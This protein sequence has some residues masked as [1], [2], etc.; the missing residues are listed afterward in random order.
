MINVSVDIET[1]GLTAG[2]H[3]VVQFAITVLDKNFELTNDRFF[4]NIKPVRPEVANP[5]ALEVNGLDL[6][7]LKTKAPNLTEIMSSLRSW[8]LEL[9]EN[10]KFL[11]LFQVAIF[12]ISFLKLALGNLY[13][14]VFD[15]HYRDTAV[16]ARALKD[17]KVIAP[18]SCKLD[19]LATYFGIVND[20]PHHALEDAKTTARVWKELIKILK[21]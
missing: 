19:D 3:E 16:L 14:T 12:D 4:T 20:K 17:A 18:E 1:T 11:P 7:F 10:E 15:Y 9:F 2:V 5:K 6:E 13:D 21:K 8:K